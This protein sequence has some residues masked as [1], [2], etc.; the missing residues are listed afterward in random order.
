M[1]GAPGAHTSGRTV[2][3]A[4][5]VADSSFVYQTIS[6]SIVLG[7]DQSVRLST[8]SDDTVGRLAQDDLGIE[9]HADYG[10]G[11][12]PLEATITLAYPEDPRLLKPR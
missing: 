4:P 12:T 8:S 7:F 9:L 6:T 1:L 10:I 11:A 2:S 3:V 5:M